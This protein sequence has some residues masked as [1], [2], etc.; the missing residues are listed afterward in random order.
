MLLEALT[1]LFT[2]SSSLSK[3]YGFL[4]SSIALEKR[5]QR[6][7]KAWRPH[8]E[9]CRKLFM[10]ALT[11]TGQKNSVVVLGSAHLHEIPLKFLLDNFNKVILID[12]QHP[13]THHLKALMNKQLELR[14]Q[15][16]TKSL[17]HLDSLTSIEDLN[18]LMTR[19]ES[20]ILFEFQADLIISANILSQLGLLPIKTLE[21]KLK[22]DLSVKEKDQICSTYAELHLKNL[23]NCQ[24][25]KIIYCDR[26]VLYFDPDGRQIYRGSYPVN[27]S[28]F[29]KITD[30]DWELAPLKEA[31]SDYSI[32]MKIHAYEAL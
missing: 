18:A 29:Q 26:E 14:T 21:K 3:K 17:G 15:D 24:G 6:C 9:N 5:Y 10:D 32:H 13:F 4:Y 31:S 12:I 20:E 27:F 2:P 28:K 25:R 8:L 22:R 30:W 19:L 23:A 16:L 7:K 1:Y 11:K